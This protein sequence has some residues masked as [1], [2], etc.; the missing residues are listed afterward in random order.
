MSGPWDV[1]KREDK[2][3]GGSGPKLTPPERDPGKVI[4]TAR[5]LGMPDNAYIESGGPCEAAGGPGCALDP[6]QRARLA[7][8]YTGRVHNAQLAYTS[9]L[10]DL[11]V[12]TLLE[13]DDVEMPW[14]LSM[15]IGWLSGYL[16][17]VI[18]RA[19]KEM[20]MATDPEYSVLVGA[21][22][23]PTPLPIGTDKQIDGI[24]AT[25]AGQ[26]RAVAIPAGGAKQTEAARSARGVTLGYIERLKDESAEMF[27]ALREGPLG[28]ASDEAM[29]AL[30]HGFRASNGHRISDYKE[31]LTAK[32]DTFKTSRAS[33][34]GTSMQAIAVQN[35]DDP[36]RAEARQMQLTTKVVWVSTVTRPER[37]LWYIDNRGDQS[38]VSTTNHAD[39]RLLDAV[40]P[41]LVDVAIDRNRAVFGEEPRQMLFDD[42]K[43]P[44]KLMMDPHAPEQAGVG[45]VEAP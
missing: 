25:V 8:L 28:T 43:S 2:L 31:M 17:I 27:Q 11:R 6:G 20:G 9:A 26:A 13:R 15:L 36:D 32:I 44:W 40:E 1:A 37:K 33:K 23:P 39:M 10:Q 4:P 42:R 29:L 16:G 35:P 3:M 45:S 12:D 41:S 5:A 19:I 18:G 22:K 34:I 38:P 14:F 24:M 30:W 21:G 7:H